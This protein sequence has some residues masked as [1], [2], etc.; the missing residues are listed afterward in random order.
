[1]MRIEVQVEIIII[2]GISQPVIRLVLACCHSNGL[3]VMS[4]LRDNVQG[5]QEKSGERGG[6]CGS[7]PRVI[8]FLCSSRVKNDLMGKT[9][10]RSALH[11]AKSKRNTRSENSYYWNLA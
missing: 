9:T 7:A 1:M 8:K 4:H 2:R 11:L 3:Q 10:I 6:A 5:G